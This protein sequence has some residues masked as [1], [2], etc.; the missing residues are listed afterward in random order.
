M[1]TKKE[2]ILFETVL[3]THTGR[4]LSIAVITE[5][6]KIVNR[7]QVIVDRLIDEM[8]TKGIFLEAM[9]KYFILKEI[10]EKSGVPE[11]EIREFTK[12]ANK[13]IHEKVAHDEMG[14]AS[15]LAI[16]DI[17][18]K[19]PECG[20]PLRLRIVPEAEG[21][22]NRFGWNSA[23]VCF[24]CGYETFSTESFEKRSMELHEKAKP[25]RMSYYR[26]LKGSMSPPG[27]K[28]Q[29]L[30]CPDCKAQMVI[31][32]VNIKKGKGNVYGYRSVM[33]CFNCGH[34]RFSRKSMEK[35]LKDLHREVKH[36]KYSL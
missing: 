17:S 36:G 11:E 10:V 1:L 7:R 33:R 27:L 21:R 26:K 18:E 6:R 20:I 24:E 31:Q 8:E 9:N 28:L 25:L 34:E 32:P 29:V 30:T 13:Q 2:K 16:E 3:P 14:M 22:K 5:A 35:Q 15:F 23:Q 19:C 12:I 4:K